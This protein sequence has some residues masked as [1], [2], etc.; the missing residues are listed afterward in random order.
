[1]LTTDRVANRVGCGLENHNAR[2]RLRIFFLGSGSCGAA[3]WFDAYTSG[4]ISQLI[5]PYK[6]PM[7]SLKNAEPGTKV[8]NLLPSIHPYG[9]PFVV[10]A[11]IGISSL[12]ERVCQSLY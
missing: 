6:R 7:A 12:R 8:N 10:L 5:A 9:V 4:V 11:A 3:A 2:S 1:M